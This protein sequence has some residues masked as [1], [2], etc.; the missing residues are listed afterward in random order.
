MRTRKK[1]NLRYLLLGGAV[2]IAVYVISGWDD[3]VRGFKDAQAD[4]PYQY[5]QAE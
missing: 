4:K 5:E 1:S 2:A 3:L